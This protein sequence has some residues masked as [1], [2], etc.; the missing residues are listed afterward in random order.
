MDSRLLQ[1]IL[2]EVNNG[3]VSVKLNSN[4][5]KEK[6]NEYNFLIIISLYR[7]MNKP[8]ICSRIAV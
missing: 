5:S 1:T 7:N 2:L 4:N 8:V 3:K 6:F